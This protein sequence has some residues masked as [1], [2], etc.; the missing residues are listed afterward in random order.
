MRMG[1]Q[2][3]AWNSRSFGAKRRGFKRARPNNDRSR[4]LVAQL[5]Q[6][7]DESLVVSPAPCGAPIDLLPHLPVARRQHRALGP[8]EIQAPSIPLETD[9]ID[10]P[11]RPMLRVL[12]QPLIGHIEQRSGSQRTAPVANEPPVLAVIM[13]EIR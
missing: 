2:P 6:G 10:D 4:A 3:R 8:V 13:G 12:D 7:P 1:N 9:E 11:A 5:E